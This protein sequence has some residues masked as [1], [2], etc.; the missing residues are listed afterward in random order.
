MI[1]TF[2]ALRIFLVTTG[3]SLLFSACEKPTDNLGF[4]QVIGGTIDADSTVLPLIKYTTEIDSILVAFEYR[5]QLQL[6]GYSSTR[7][8][9]IYQN[10][11]FGEA[12]A[13]MLSQLL[14][15]QLNPDFGDNAVLDSVNLY[16]R[17]TDAYGDTSVP[18]NIEVYELSQGFSRDSNYF[19]NY[20]PT[21]GELLGQISNFRPEPNR[22]RPFE[23]GEFAA[24]F[25]RIPLDRNYFQTRFVDVGDGSFAPF[26]DFDEFIDYFKGL[27]VECTQAGA[28]LDL[29]LASNFSNLRLYYHN[30]EDTNVVEF[31][32]DQGR[33]VVPIT[34]STFE[35]DYQSARFDLRNQDTV[36][37]EEQTF[38]Q[39]MGGVATALKID[40]RALEE[41]IGEGAVINKASLILST[42]LGTGDPAQPSERMELRILEGKGLG[43]RTLDFQDNSGDGALRLGALRN[44]RYEFDLTRHLFSVLNSG[45]NNTLAVV[46]TARTTAASHTILRGGSDPLKNAQLVVYF[47]KP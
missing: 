27:K 22:A 31:N 29:N 21:V 12:R 16:L 25:I 11:Y 26:S 20:N 35:Q 32:F 8:F 37:G 7:L 33:S 14:P 38:V 3:L 23:D 17:M 15:R 42:D 19:S 36:D 10:P 6:G 2:A 30:S 18:M 4:N 28:I 41:R 1:R 9:G 34:F 24:P 46:P 45:E 39:A 47:T 5:F 44:N 40:P 13:T 43:S